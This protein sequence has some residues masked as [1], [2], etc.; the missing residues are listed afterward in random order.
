MCFVYIEGGKGA[1][2]YS[3]GSNHHP[4]LGVLGCSTGFTE[5]SMHHARQCGIDILVDQVS[6]IT[7]VDTE[8]SGKTLKTD[9]NQRTLALSQPAKLTHVHANAAPDDSHA[10]AAQAAQNVAVIN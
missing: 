6:V 10:N 4:A 2:G 5:K 9:H 7:H 3:S 8:N 1:G